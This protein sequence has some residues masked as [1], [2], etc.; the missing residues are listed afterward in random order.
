V[1]AAIGAFGGPP[2]MMVSPGWGFGTICAAVGRLKVAAAPAPPA[3]PMTSLRPWIE[4][5]SGACGNFVG[6]GPTS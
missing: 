3:T 2:A 4:K 1:T 5:Q 6:A